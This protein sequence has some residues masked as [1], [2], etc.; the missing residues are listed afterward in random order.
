MKSLLRV[1]MNSI[2]VLAAAFAFGLPFPIAAQ[3][4]PVTAEAPPPH[5]PPTAP[6]IVVTNRPLRPLPQINPPEGATPY[7]IGQPTD[8]EQQYLEYLNRARSNP[9]AEGAILAATTDP[10]VLAAYNY[11]M[12]NLTEMQ[13]QFDAITA[14][15]PLAMNAELTTAARIHS[16]D[17]FTNAYQGHI[18]TDGTDPGDRITAQGYVWD[19]YGENV[20]SYSYSV[21]YGHA[22]FEV[23]WGGSSATGG[24]QSPPGHRDNIH[25]SSFRE[26]GVGVVD[27]SNTTTNGTVGP[28]LVTQDLGATASG[29][30]FITGVAYYDLNGNN[31]YDLGEGIGGATI[32]TP[33]STYFAITA[34]SGGYAIPITTNGNYTLTFSGPGFV[35]TQRVVTVSGLTNVKVDFTPG[36]SPP[37]LAG[38]NPAGV[39]ENNAY[40]FN[41]IGGAT[42]Y[43]WMQTYLVSYTNVEGAEHGLTNVTVIT[44]PGY[45]V[46]TNT[47]HA[48]GSYC[49]HLSHTNAMAGYIGL[50]P[51]LV[52]G[53]N[54]QLS[55]AKQLGYATSDEVARAQISTNGGASWTDLWTEAG[56]TLDSAFVSITNSLSSYAGLPCRI[57]FAYSINSG[58][59]YYPQTDASVGLC[60][61]NIAFTNTEQAQTPVTN[62]I[63]SN[64]LVFV[65]TSSGIYQL[66]VRAL[67]PG[68]M[69]PWGPTLQVAASN[70]P[71]V[72]IQFSGSPVRSAGQVQTL[73]TVGNYRNGLPLQ[74]QSAS[75]P[76]GPWTPDTI[77][78]LQ[79]VVSNS[80]FRLTATNV[81]SHSFF[82]VRAN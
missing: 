38:S 43:Q 6:P 32:Q 29:T 21:F 7:S 40:S 8:E 42:N 4:Q 77:S 68:R 62:S 25:D 70:L 22:G 41:A 48:S 27:G 49:F 34:N 14:S 44:S 15:P 55:F 54:S 69:L 67:L 82:R 53:A 26:V 45:S 19:T 72:T 1:V 58:G 17:M 10:N 12:V 51:T 81:N 11:F 20:F 75:N 52:P 23:D 64:S 9:P 24:M 30:P 47:F 71:P 74:I 50:D 13:S 56:G 37:V 31:F 79:T 35:T 36:Y 28:Q 59:S 2:P 61:D 5:A 78:T 76:A 57:Q 66:S 18:G 39:N 73:F 33:G 16:G 3:W 80:Q 65:P 63:S 46:I 60:L